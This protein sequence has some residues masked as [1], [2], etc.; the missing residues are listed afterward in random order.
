MS[1]K[2]DIL[3]DVLKKNRCKICN[4]DC[5]LISSLW[6]RNK[7]MLFLKFTS[8]SSKLPLNPSKLPQN[9]FNV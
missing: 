6:T 4:I 8:K 5:A 1:D 9:Y 3:S 7:K 2:S